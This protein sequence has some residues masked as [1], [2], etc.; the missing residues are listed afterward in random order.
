MS[1]I[2]TSRAPSAFTTATPAAAMAKAVEL[3][4]QGHGDIKVVTDD[5]QILDIEDFEQ[6]YAGLAPEDGL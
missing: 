5:G 6:R 1:F 3:S 4:E 2:V